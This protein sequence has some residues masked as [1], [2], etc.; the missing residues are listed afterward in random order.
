MKVIVAGSRFFTDY[1][2]VKRYLDVFRMK[3]EIEE[4]VS[5]A[6]DMGNLTF[7]REN[8]SKV[9]GVDGLGERYAN[10][11]GIPVK[12]FPANWKKFGLSAGPVRNGEMAVYGNYAI[13]ISDG[14]SRGS[15]SMIQKAKYYKIPC[16][17]I[18]IV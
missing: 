3:Y 9:F 7:V 18:T 14:L 5:G 12:H 13:V 10:E 17:E 4:I 1:E 11:H 2:Y 8:G 16:N 15:R 6:C